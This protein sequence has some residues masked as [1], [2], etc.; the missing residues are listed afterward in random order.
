MKLYNF[1]SFYIVH[2][3]YNPT[4]QAIIGLCLHQKFILNFIFVNYKSLV[5][6]LIITIWSTKFYILKKEIKN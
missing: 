6:Q 1:P 3:L 4:F 5:C 2:Y